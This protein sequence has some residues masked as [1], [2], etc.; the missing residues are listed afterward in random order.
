MLSVGIANA[1]PVVNGN[2]ITWTDE[3]WHQVQDQMTFESLC[4]DRVRCTV[5]E[6]VY[7]VI[8]HTTGERFKNV[9]V[10][11]RSGG[12]VPA[13]VASTGQTTSYAFGD[14]GDYQSGVTVAERYRSNGDGTFTD[15]LTGLVWL[16]V[17]NCFEQA[18]WAG[19]LTRANEF[20]ADSGVCPDLDDGSVAGDWRLPNLR[21]LYSLVDITADTALLSPAIPFTGEL[22]ILLL[23]DYWTSSSFRPVPETT[24]WTIEANFGR[25]VVTPKTELGLVWPVR[26]SD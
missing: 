2:V 15:T 21:E 11:D 10:V 5:P 14:D 13:P 24:G 18:D 9:A 12:G 22:G 7:I 1:A 8:N 19:A 20:A 25:Q 3:G 17:R 26:D 16:A 4:E 23:G 6:G